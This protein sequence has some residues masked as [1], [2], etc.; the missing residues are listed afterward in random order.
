MRADAVKG[1]DQVAANFAALSSVR[2]DFLILFRLSIGVR[3]EF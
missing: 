1:R 2:I 3:A